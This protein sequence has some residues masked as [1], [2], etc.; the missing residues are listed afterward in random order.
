MRARR[1]GGLIFAAL[2][3]FPILAACTPV[4]PPVRVEVWGDS[5]G[6]QS[7]DYSNFFLGYNHHATSRVA[8]FPRR[9]GSS[10]NT[11]SPKRPVAGASL[12]R[13]ASSDRVSGASRTN[14][15][16]Q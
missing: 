4:P 13:G 9:T 8:T 11:A 15:T 10:G 3:A 2:A 12:Y 6:Q 16:S 7:G 1:F 5:I 14:H